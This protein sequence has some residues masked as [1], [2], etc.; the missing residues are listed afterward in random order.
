VPGTIR[1]LHFQA[2][3]FV[4]A[5]LIRVLSGRIFDVVIDLQSSSN[6]YGKHATIELSEAGGQQL[7]VPAGFA[8]G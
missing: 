8:H 1:G 5:K 7:L 2:P 6:T 3:P 4:Q